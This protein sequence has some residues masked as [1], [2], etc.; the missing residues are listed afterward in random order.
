M[1]SHLSC[2]FQLFPTKKKKKSGLLLKRASQLESSCAEPSSPVYICFV[3]VS[4][5]LPWPI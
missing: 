2:F 5:S 3:Y 1:T 4:V